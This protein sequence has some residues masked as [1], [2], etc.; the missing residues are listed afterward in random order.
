MVGIQCVVDESRDEHAVLKVGGERAEVFRDDITGQ[1]LIPELV[2]A[3][4]KKE[5][6]YFDSKQVWS[7][8]STEEARRVGKR[9]VGRRQ[10]WR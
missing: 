8:R 3:A 1:P 5:L 2:H 9:Q 10:Q 4:R 7:V 6:D